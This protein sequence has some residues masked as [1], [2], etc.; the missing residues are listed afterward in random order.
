[1]NE[2]VTRETSLHLSQTIYY[3]GGYGLACCV[4]LGRPPH[5]F[6]SAQHE[7]LAL[8]TP[9]VASVTSLAFKTISAASSRSSVRN[10]G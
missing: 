2:L 8:D 9:P 10:P 3:V 6:D 5:Y 4:T 1:V 7:L